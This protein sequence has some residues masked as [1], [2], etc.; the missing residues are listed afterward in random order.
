MLYCAVCKTVVQ[1]GDNQCRSCGNGFVSRLACAS[2]NKIVTIGV[3]SCP[4]CSRS[5]MAFDVVPTPVRPLPS[6]LAPV[7]RSVPYV[8][9]EPVP[10]AVVLHPPGKLRLPPGLGL[11]ELT[12]PEQRRDAGRFGAIA[13]VTMNGNDAEIMTRMNQ[14]AAMLHVLAQDMNGFQGVD[15]ETRSVIRGCRNLAALLQEEVERRRGP[16]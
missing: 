7:Q 12:V 2:C 9:A 5:S 10:S 15:P 11:N 3:S 6:S 1:E 14:V 13:D 8:V 16:A 4:A